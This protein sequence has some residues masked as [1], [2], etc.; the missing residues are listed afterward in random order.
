MITAD[1]W[2]DRDP[3]LS[4]LYQG[5]VV[6]S[7]PFP[8]WPTFDSENQ[9]SKWAILR[10]QLQENRPLEQVLRALPNK[11]I[12]RAASDVPDA[13]KHSS[14]ELIIASCLLVEVMIVSRSCS[15]DNPAKKHH[16][17]AP[18]VSVAT[19]ALEQRTEGM[20]SELRQGNIPHYFYLPEAMDRSESYAD[21]RRITPMHRSF[22]SRELAQ[23][24]LAVRLTSLAQAK[25]QH[26][27]SEHFGRG[28]GF[29]HEDICPQ[30]GTYGCSVC[31]HNGNHV[32]Y[33]Q[34]QGG[35]RFGTCPQCGERAA[36]V[37]IPPRA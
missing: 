26:A 15:L 3:D 2:Y 14:H 10:P 17:V 7:V 21:L 24:N 9:S 35:I 20:L 16:L 28:F 13:F 30:D 32:E 19:L 12:G 1:D 23:A 22:F 6:R 29:D 27:L 4:M 5:D 18:M 25:L 31:F 36:Y 8:K 34:F 11:L 37:K 33:R